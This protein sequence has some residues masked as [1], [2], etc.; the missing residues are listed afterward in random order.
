MRRSFA[1]AMLLVLAFAGLALA[2]ALDL[3]KEGMRRLSAGDFKAAI[4]L[5]GQAIDSGQIAPGSQL[6]YACHVNRGM[7]HANRQDYES[8]LA[9]YN[10]AIKID[11]NLAVAYHNRGRIWH[12]RRKFDIA[13]ADYDLAIALNPKYLGAYLSRAKAFEALGERVKAAAD[14]A[15]AR[16]L[17]PKAQ[18]PGF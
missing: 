10:A 2:D 17:D 5:F 4:T 15:R 12:H 3:Y 6:L 7:A 1:L 14:L 18:M 13:V 16:Q 11:P 8:A 9:D